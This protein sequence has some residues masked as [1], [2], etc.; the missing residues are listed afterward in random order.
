MDRSHLYAL[1]QNLS[2][3]R[4]RLHNAKSNG[5]RELRKVWVNQLEKQITDESK[6]LGIYWISDEVEM[7]SNDELLAELSA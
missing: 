7:M 3:E 4:V 2:H 6:H 5:E 1:E